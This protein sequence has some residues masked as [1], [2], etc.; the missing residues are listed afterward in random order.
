MYPRDDATYRYQ[1]GGDKEADAPLPII[2]IDGRRHREEEGR[3]PRGE[4]PFIAGKQLM[5][6]KVEKGSRA[7]IEEADKL[8]RAEAR[9]KRRGEDDKNHPELLSLRVSGEEKECEE[10]DNQ[11]IREIRREKYEKPVEERRSPRKVVQKEK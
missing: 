3:V 8:H 7:M 2:E 5:D 6:R 9:D 1:S 4:G 11:K 10:E